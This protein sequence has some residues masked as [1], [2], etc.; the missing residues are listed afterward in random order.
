MQTKLIEAHEI[1]IIPEGMSFGNFIRLGCA[2]KDIKIKELCEACNMNYQIFSTTYRYYT[3]RPEWLIEIADYFNVSLKELIL[4]N[5][6]N[7][8]DTRNTKKAKK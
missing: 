5:A 1:N 7:T 2:E 8:Q 6:K 3:I 4:L